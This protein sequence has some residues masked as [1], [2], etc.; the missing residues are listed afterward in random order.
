MIIV[1]CSGMVGK[2]LYGQITNALTD[3]ELHFDEVRKQ[4]SEINFKLSG[5]MDSSHL[6]Q[7][8]NITDFQIAA[9]PSSW[10]AGWMM[11]TDDLRWLVKRR[12]LQQI[13]KTVPDLTR[14]ERLNL[15]SLARQRELHLRRIALL[16]NSQQLFRY[17][18]I[19]HL[20]LAQTMYIVTILHIVIAIY[21]GYLGETASPHPNSPRAVRYFLILPWYLCWLLHPP[22]APQITA[23]VSPGELF[24]RIQNFQESNCATVTDE[25][26]RSDSGSV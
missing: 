9:N 23:L 13:L 8:Q 2:Y 21:T 12:R 24:A 25:Q 18:H 22:R 4:I 3:H 11:I 16:R 1:M 10:R 15:Y 19:L 6:K 26:R 20:P 7:V 5:F 14:D 17:W